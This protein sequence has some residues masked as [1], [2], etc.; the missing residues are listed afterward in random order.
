M[1]ELIVDEFEKQLGLERAAREAVT[2]AEQA[3]AALFER[4]R[5]SELTSVDAF[6][7][8]LSSLKH[9]RGSLIAL[10]ELRAVDLP[11]V[12]RLEQEVSQRFGEVSRACVDFFLAENA[13]KPL[14]DRLDA[15]VTDV[16]GVQKT[17]ELLPSQKEL[18]A[19]HEGLSLLSET[20]EGLP[21][22]DPTVRTKI[23]EGT[24]SAFAQQNRARAVLDARRKELGANEGRA[25]FAVEFKLLGQSVTSA[26]S[27]SNTPEAC[28]EQL[29]KLMLRLESLEARFGEL[30]EFSVK[31]AEKREELLDAVSTRRTQLVEERQRRAHNLISAGQRILAGVAR[32]VQGVQSVEELNGYF[33]SDAMVQ[34][35]VE[36]ARQLRE[37]GRLGA[38]RRARLQAQGR[39]AKCAA[40]AARSGR[41]ARR[42]RQSDSLRSASLQREH[43][44]ARAQHRAPRRS[45]EYPP[46]GHRFLRAAI[47]AGA[48]F[49]A[50]IC[51]S[52]ELVSET[53]TSIAASI[54]R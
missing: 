23:L 51:G 25:E 15:L 36:L 33:A 28:D 43:P 12:E 20:I 45:A 19:V 30:D 34:K 32:R 14:L 21:I 48:R 31:L 17:A 13:F 9:Q 37:L 29:A 39:E 16:G 52:S 8:G 26:L 49:G 24:S 5:S 50:R 4:V 6:L 38:R 44:P 35:L 27:L 41:P 46:D 47:G 2:K 7:S 22:D 3:Q 54:S 53:P 42:R 1:S 10:R 40:R 11:T 18:D